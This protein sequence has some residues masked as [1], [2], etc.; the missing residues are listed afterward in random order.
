MGVC[1]DSSGNVFVTAYHTEDVLEFAHGGTTPIA[2]LGDYGY[3]PNGCAVDPTTGNLAVA[4]QR[5]MDNSGGNI[6]IYA[7]AQG[8]PTDYTTQSGGDGFTWCAYDNQGNLLADMDGGNGYAEMPAGSQTLNGF[9]MNVSGQG[10]QW[11]GSYFAIVNPTAKQVYRVS[12]NGSSGNV[13]STIT[14]KG[15][16]TTLGDDFVFAR[17]KILMPYGARNNNVTRIAAGKYPQARLGKP[18]H[19]G[20]KG[21]SFY[22]LAL[23]I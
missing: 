18:L 2:K 21:H 5:A 19:V 10:I 3:Y 1:S 8:K 17:S 15:L 22:S 12:V 11:D 23:S 9:T 6:A 4:N 7:H 16:F 13:V 14:Y 20:G